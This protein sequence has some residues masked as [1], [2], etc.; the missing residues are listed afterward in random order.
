MKVYVLELNFD[1]ECSTVIGVF[2]SQDLA[3]GFINNNYKVSPWEIKHN[4]LTSNKLDDEERTTQDY[5]TIQE[6]EI[7]NV[8]NL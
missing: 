4:F 1:Y 7:D 6:V 3:K 8:Q 2:S 5:F